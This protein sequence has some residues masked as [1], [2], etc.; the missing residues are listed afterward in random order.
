MKKTAF[1]GAALVAAVVGL[2]STTGCSSAP[3]ETSDDNAKASEDALGRDPANC[4]FHHRYKKWNTQC[5]YG[6]ATWDQ[7][8]ALENA[9]THLSG[10]GACAEFGITIAG[11]IAGT[12]TVVLTPASIGAAALAAGSAA[13]CG[14]YI[15]DVL[16][17]II[18]TSCVT[19]EVAP[20]DFER[21]SHCA[22]ACG[23]SERLYNGDCYC[24][25]TPLACQDLPAPQ[26]TPTPCTTTSTTDGCFNTTSCPLQSGRANCSGTSNAST[27][28]TA[29]NVE[30]TKYYKCTPQG[31]RAC[32]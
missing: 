28:S 23:G 32:R 3:E 14:L 8:S 9:A 24:G 6:N 21:S 19:W 2:C 16:R 25:R 22:M 7:R 20:S 13:G 29:I 31:W 27:S 15:T 17:N 4:Y 10:V 11:A 12:F 30:G 18:P 1:M 26:T 5:T